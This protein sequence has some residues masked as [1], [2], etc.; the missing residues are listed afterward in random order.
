MTSLF[1]FLTH[2]AINN[3]APEYLSDLINVNYKGTTVHTR[4]SFDPCLLCV[5]PLSKMCAN[6]CFMY[7]APTLWNAL[8][9]RVLPFDAFKKRIKT[10]LYLM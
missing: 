10:H 8:D 4:A 5:P 1:L 2:K 7:D 9:I 6:P 3:S